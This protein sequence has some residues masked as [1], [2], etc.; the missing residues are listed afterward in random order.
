MISKIK[1]YFNTRVKNP[2]DEQIISSQNQVRTAAAALLVE[3]MVTDGLISQNEETT[4]KKLLENGFGL[5]TL[6]AEE[7][8]QL[9]KQEVTEAT[10]LYQFTG[11]VNE[12]FSTS[13]KFDLLT[14]TWQVA[15]ADGTL[16]KY[17]ENLIR[18]LA[19]LLHI[20]HSRFIKAKSLA[21]ASLSGQ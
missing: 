20:G 11:L 15:L 3:I 2:T 19:D 8:F 14:Q 4:I 18:R 7:L 1:T 13:E 9:A 21:K 6:E 16:D 10:S 5:S 17:E 12:H